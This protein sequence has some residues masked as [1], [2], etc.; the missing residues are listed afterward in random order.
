MNE[1]ILLS[2]GKTPVA[3]E[4]LDHLW[5]KQPFKFR[6][7][8]TEYGPSRE[9]AH[10][11]IEFNF[12][13][14][15]ELEINLDGRDCV[16]K[17]GEVLFV[18]QYIVHQ[19]TTTPSVKF[20]HMIISTKFLQE[21]GINLSELWFQEIILADREIKEYFCRLEEEHRDRKPFF[22]TTMQGLI[23]ELIVHLVRN[24]TTKRTEEA[25]TYLSKFGTEFGYVKIAIDYIS[26]NIHKNLTVE[27][28]SNAAG[29]SQ[30]HFM[31][32]FKRVTKYTLSDYINMRRCE[33]ARTMILSGEC[34]ITEAALSSG[35]SNLSYFAKVFKKVTGSLPTEVSQN[36]K[37]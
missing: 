24:Y 25:D 9:C 17:K 19:V 26:E 34:T 4:S 13:T 3:Y 27:E 10:K 20:I 23:L 37:R 2:E 33:K 5:I 32:I 29:I 16:I 15:G 7:C 28:I 21:N 30:Y 6:L 31:R 12:I 14:E 11:D 22:K 36:K 35:F 1:R 18:N 8:P